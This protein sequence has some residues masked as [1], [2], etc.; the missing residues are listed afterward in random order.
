MARSLRIEYNGAVYRIT[1]RGNKKE[2]IFTSN[3]DRVLFLTIHLLALFSSEVQNAS[4]KFQE[5][6]SLGN[7]RGSPWHR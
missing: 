6:V 2:N 1:S 5:Y 3:A 7:L 4:K